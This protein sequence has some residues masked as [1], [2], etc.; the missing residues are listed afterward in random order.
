[1]IHII[2]N[3]KINL[4]ED[5][6]KLYQKIVQSYTTQFNKGEDLFIDLF[7]TDNNGIIIFIKPPSTRRTTFEA[8]LFLIAIMQQ[9]HLR[10]I[11]DQVDDMAAQIKLKLEEIDKKLNSI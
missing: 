2:D 3:K 1:M 6:W 9:Q 7:E 10:M 8:F 11:H 4:T 5:E